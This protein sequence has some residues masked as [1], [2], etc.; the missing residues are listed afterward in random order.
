MGDYYEVV[1]GEALALRAYMHFDLLRLFAPYDFTA[2]AEPAIPYV[3][4]AVP[5]I[6]PQ[7]TP[8]KFVELA[9]ADV[10][11]ALGLL[12]RIRF[13][14]VLMLRERITVIWLTGIST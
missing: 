5:A 9:L 1:K 12:K 10:D 13:I 14:P 11:D 3:R 8:A 7:L 4:E 6:A 2:E